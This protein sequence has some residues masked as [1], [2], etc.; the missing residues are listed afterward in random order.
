M[1]KLPNIPKIEWKKPWVIAVAAALIVVISGSVIV[2]K[3]AGGRKKDGSDSAILPEVKTVIAEKKA[4]TDAVDAYGNVSY[5]KKVNV[6]A[7]IEEVLERIDIDIGDIVYEG[8]ALAQLKTRDIRMNYDSSRQELRSKDAALNLATAK[9]DNALQSAEKNIG[10]LDRLRN[11]KR[12]KEI[13]LENLVRVLSNKKALLDVDGL[14]LEKYRELEN[15]YAITK[16]QAESVSKQL[17]AAEIGYRDL[18][19]KNAGLIIPVDKRRRVETLKAMNSKVEQAEVT[20]AQSEKE[21]A[22]LQMQSSEQLLKD[23]TVRSPLNGVIAMKYLEPGEKATKDK[24]ICTVIDIERVYIDI[25][26]PETDLSRIRPNQPVEIKV[27]AYPE[28]KFGG[29]VEKLFPMIDTKTRTVTVRCLIRNKRTDQKKYMLLP[30]MFVRA[31]I[32]TSERKN[33]LVLPFSAMAEKDD[34]RVKLFILKKDPE[35]PNMRMTVEKWAVAYRVSESGIEIA[36]G[37]SEGDEVAVTGLDFLSTGMR[38]AVKDTPK[39]TANG[40]KYE[41]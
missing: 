33:A 40:E 1:I 14:P 29:T 17:E 30:G 37:V 21:K 35:K 31:N 34:M 25:P 23:A 5:Y 22:I 36:D 6:T 27:D 18:D 10:S 9:Y 11:D 13:E 38:V 4:I 15:S 20:I 32:V 3:I 8:Q 7:K 28:Q 19:I 16:L 24:P 12:Q 2:S 41:K 39:M 26:V